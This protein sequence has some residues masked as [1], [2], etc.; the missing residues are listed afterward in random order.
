MAMIIPEFLIKGEPLELP[1]DNLPETD[2]VPL[3][4]AWHRAA[5]A[6]LIE[7]VVCRMQ[8]QGRTDY[9][10]GGNMFIYFSRQ[11]ARDRDYRGPDFFFV[12]DLFQNNFAKL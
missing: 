5:I 3:E 4:S 11:Q 2:G 9:Y 6:L 10:V 8:G 12:K 1:P 7:S